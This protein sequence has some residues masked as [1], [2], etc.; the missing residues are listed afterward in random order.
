[1]GQCSFFWCKGTYNGVII[2]GS[3]ASSIGS[4]AAGIDGVSYLETAS[5]RGGSL[6][7]RIRAG[8]VGTFRLAFVIDGVTAVGFCT[9]SY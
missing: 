8:E 5:T 7:P 2:S 1:M 3:G 6:P 9:G 4:Y